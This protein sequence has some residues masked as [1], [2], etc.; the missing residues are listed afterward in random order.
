MSRFVRR[1]AILPFE[2]LIA[3]LVIVSG[4]LA[5][6]HVGGIGQDVLSLQLPSWL[7]SI[8]NV[9]YLASGLGM[10]LGIA[11]NLSYAEASGLMG[12]ASG[13]VIRGLA[14][15]WFA[16]DRPEVRASVVVGLVFDAMIVVAC[17]IRLSHLFQHKVLVLAEVEKTPG[18]QA[19]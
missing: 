1:L 3:G 14:L 10:L 4:S 13:A 17:A 9:L 8:L 5:L 16:W 15:V 12:V 18:R 2:V 6:V 11:W 7:T 19:P